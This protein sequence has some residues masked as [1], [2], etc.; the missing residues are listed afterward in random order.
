MCAVKELQLIGVF[1]DADYIERLRLSVEVVARERAERKRRMAE[2]AVLSRY[3]FGENDEI[4]WDEGD[5][6]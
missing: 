2:A 6:K 1:I 5:D 3:D 4:P